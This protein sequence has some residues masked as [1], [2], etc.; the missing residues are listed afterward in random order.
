LLGILLA[1]FP[2]SLFRDVGGSAGGP[3]R[4]HGLLQSIDQRRLRDPPEP[5]IRPRGVQCDA[6]CFPRPRRGV[7]RRAAAP[8][9]PRRPEVVGIAL[10]DQL[11]DTSASNFN[12]MV[13]GTDKAPA[14]IMRNVT[15]D[16]SHLLTRRTY[17][18]LS[19]L[20]RERIADGGARDG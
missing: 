11:V 13:E 18:A 17:L 10:A 6:V 15:G 5:L 16:I 4:L 14:K 1:P 8:G 3:E 19:Q 20:V 2:V 9:Q 12:Q 7:D